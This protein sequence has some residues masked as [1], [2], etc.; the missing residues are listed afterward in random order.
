MAGCYSLRKVELNRP[1]F[2]RQPSTV[3]VQSPLR[4]MVNVIIEDGRITG[5]EY[6]R[7]ESKDGTSKKLTSIVAS[8][9]RA[10][11]IAEYI[12]HPDRINYPLRRVG[13]RGENPFE[14]DPI[15]MLEKEVLM[16]I[17]NILVGACVGKVAELLGDYVSY[18]PPRVLIGNLAQ[19]D[20]TMNMFNPDD[21]VIVL[22]TVFHFSD[23]H[24]NGYLFLIVSC[25]S[26]DWLKQGLNNFM[27][28]YE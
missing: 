7:R 27:R 21:V 18:S 28:Q 20:V 17:G 23:R 13:K 1:P 16:E 26:V 8:C 2:P 14:S 6:L 12:D 25:E 15:G 22:K 11:G 3:K 9:L 5:Q 4:L 10:R 19:T 24:V